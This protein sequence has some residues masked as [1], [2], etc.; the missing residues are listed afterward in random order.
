[1]ERSVNR[2]WDSRELARASSASSNDA[3]A[4]PRVG[5]ALDVV[6]HGSVLGGHEPPHAGRLLG[7]V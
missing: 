7:R 4:L 1:M 3:F 6:N 2:R 5:E